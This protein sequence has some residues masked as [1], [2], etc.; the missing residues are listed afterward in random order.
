[1]ASITT[2]TAPQLEEIFG[3]LVEDLRSQPNTAENRA[4]YTKLVTALLRKLGTHYSV[5]VSFDIDAGPTGNMDIF[6]SKQMT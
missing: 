3:K 5:P 2:A 1:M 6:F 4:H